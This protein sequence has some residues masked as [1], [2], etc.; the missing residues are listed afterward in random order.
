MQAICKQMHYQLFRLQQQL[1]TM[2][3]NQFSIHIILITQIHSQILIQIT[4][5]ERQQQ[6]QTIITHMEMCFS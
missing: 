6:E 4:Q 5:Q 3:Q 2:I 1:E